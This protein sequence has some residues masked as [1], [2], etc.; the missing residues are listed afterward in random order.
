MSY[1]GHTQTICLNGHYRIWDCYSEPDVCSCGAAFGMV[2]MVDDTNGE[3]AY[4]IQMADLAK[5]IK[6]PADTCHCCGHQTSEPLY[7]IPT[8]LERK[9]M[10]TVRYDGGDITY[11]M[12]QQS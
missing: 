12:K 7:N 2:N 10:Q 1:E 11:I 3:S 8:E 9:A 4:E 5:F 6:K